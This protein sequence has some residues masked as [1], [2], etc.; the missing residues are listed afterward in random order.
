MSRHIF[1]VLLLLTFVPTVAES[2]IDPAPALSLRGA[3]AEALARNPELIA[4][5]Q[6]YEAARAAPALE[7]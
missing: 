3:I 2:Q 5:R 4:L 1:G 7:R 6:Q